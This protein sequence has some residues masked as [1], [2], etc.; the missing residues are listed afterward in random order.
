MGLRKL[1]AVIVRN[2]DTQATLANALGLC[3]SSLNARILKKTDFKQTEMD[4]IKKRYRLSNDEFMDIFF[5]D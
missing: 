2:G 1:K 5:T 3:V 4:A